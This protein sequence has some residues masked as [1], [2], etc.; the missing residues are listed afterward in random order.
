MASK[1]PRGRTNISGADNTPSTQPHHD[2]AD[3]VL[4]SRPV[5]AGNGPHRGDRRD[6]HPVFTGN[7]KHAARGDTPRK[8]GRSTRKA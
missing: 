7:E 5:K 6:M 8:T 2:Q 4:S 3:K 1:K